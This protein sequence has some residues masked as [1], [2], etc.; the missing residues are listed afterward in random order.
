MWCRW[1]VEP[2]WGGADGPGSWNTALGKMRDPSGL[3]KL[4][5]VQPVF[6]IFCHAV[7]GVL[8]VTAQFILSQGVANNL[9]LCEMAAC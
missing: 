4:W 8:C 2:W 7:P 3:G 1:E 9:I 6:A 5:W